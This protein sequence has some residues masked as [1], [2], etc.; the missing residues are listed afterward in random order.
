[1]GVI[2]LTADMG[3]VKLTCD[4]VFLTADMGLVKLV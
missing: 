2:C 1:M 3:L 4:G